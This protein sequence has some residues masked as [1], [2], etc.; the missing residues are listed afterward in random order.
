MNV[1]GPSVRDIDISSIFHRVEDSEP[2]AFHYVLLDPSGLPELPARLRRHPR[3]ASN[4]F[5]LEGQLSAQAVSPLLLPWQPSP[6]SG[7]WRDLEHWIVDVASTSASVLWISSP[8][9]REVL[10]KRLAQRVN[11]LLPDSLEVV[12][13]FFDTRVFE[14]LV[15]LLA[16]PIRAHFLSPATQWAFVGRR[17]EMIRIAS[18][19]AIN[20]PLEQP[21]LLDVA[22]ESALIDAS[23]PDQIADM[24]GK[25]VPDAYLGLPFEERYDFI[26]RHRQHA[27]TLGIESSFDLSL[28]CALAL[29]HGEDFARREPWKSRLEQ[30]VSGQS[31][32]SEVIVSVE[33]AISADVSSNP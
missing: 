29:Q 24:L 15:Q 2:A 27:R 12:L 25:T 5:R 10:A 16:P 22:T 31:S 13:R 8:L 9:S 3:P 6:E 26:V 20:E 21:L 17:G 19:F 30:C 23:E 11:A 7:T 4:L 33:D 14:A 1:Q 28:Y 18:E 32:L